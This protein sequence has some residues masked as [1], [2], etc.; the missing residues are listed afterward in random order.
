MEDQNLLAKKI[1][2]L[3]KEKNL[4]QREVADKLGVSEQA[5]SKWETGGS[6]P[7]INILV[8]LARLL[9]TD[10]NTLLAFQSEP[11]PEEMARLSKEIQETGRREGLDAAYEMVQRLM[12]EYPG[13]DQLTFL[14]ANALHALLSVQSATLEET[15]RYGEEIERLYRG[16]LDCSDETLRGQVNRMLFYWY[17]RKE[18]TDRMEE[19]LRN[20][21]EDDRAYHEMG[22]L[23]YRTKG[24]YDKAREHLERGL[25]LHV[26]QVQGLISQLQV[27]A[28]KEEDIAEALSLAETNSALV[29]RMGLWEYGAYS[30]FLEPYTVSKNV[31][32]LVRTFRGMMEAAE[33]P[34]R[35]ADSQLFRHLEK[36]KDTKNAEEQA[37]KMTRRLQSDLMEVLEREESLAF[38]RESEEGQA[39]LAEM[40]HKLE[41]VA[42]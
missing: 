13:C 11:S 3:R 39:L 29:R 21:P 2:S 20:I 4:T 26:A 40:R 15:A 30:C 22:A 18:Q 36:V 35:H 27:I 42:Y 23:L 38:L 25:M 8:P 37:K 14:L 19:I 16:L 28:L 24:E 9:G 32:G 34:W 7:D 1:Q 12:R 5:V 33:K 17:A 6:C 41:S 31:E 10:V